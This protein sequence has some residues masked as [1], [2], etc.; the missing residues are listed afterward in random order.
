[1]IMVRG[2]LLPSAEDPVDE[3]ETLSLDKATCEASLK[4]AE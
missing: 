4:N 1:M 2:G 3:G